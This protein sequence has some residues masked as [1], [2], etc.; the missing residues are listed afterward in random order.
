MHALP[1]AGWKCG[2]MRSLNTPLPG[3]GATLRRATAVVILAWYADTQDPH[4]SSPCI[5]SILFAYKETFM[6]L[7]A[8]LNRCITLKTHYPSPQ[9]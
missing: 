2:F 3:A 1:V 9:Q 5:V 8:T 4:Q 6:S 7:Y